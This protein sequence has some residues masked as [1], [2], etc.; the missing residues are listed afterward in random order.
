MGVF[1][2]FIKVYVLFEH[3]NHLV[4]VHKPDKDRKY[5]HINEILTESGEPIM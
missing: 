3:S 1:S 2:G 5:D 4:R